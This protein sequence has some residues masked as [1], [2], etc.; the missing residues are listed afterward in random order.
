MRVLESRFF[1]QLLLTVAVILLW[2]IIT[3]YRP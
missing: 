1:W 3:A 2:N